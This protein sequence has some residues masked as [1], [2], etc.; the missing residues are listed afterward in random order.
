M[1]MAPDAVFIRIPPAGPG[2]SDIWNVT[3]PVVC[4]KNDE[5]GGVVARASAGTSAADPYQQPDQ[6]G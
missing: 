4:M 1:I 2:R 5:R 3:W 6:I